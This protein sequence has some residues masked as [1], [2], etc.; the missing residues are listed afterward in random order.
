MKQISIAVIGG[1]GLYQ[2]DQLKNPQEHWLDTPF[3]KTLRFLRGMT[4]AIL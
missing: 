1:S 2:M 3:G 4:E